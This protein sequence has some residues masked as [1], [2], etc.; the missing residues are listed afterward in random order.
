[1]KTLKI[2]A[3]LLFAV[4][5]FIGAAACAQNTPVQTSTTASVT[6]SEVS[7]IVSDESVEEESKSPVPEQWQDNGIF[8]NYYE[9]A[10]LMMSEL[11]LEEKIGQML[12]TR[13]PDTDAAATA[14]KYNIGGYVLFGR[15]FENKTKDDVIRTIRSYQESSKIPMA[16]ASDEEGGTVT[17]VSW[18][19]NLTEHFFQSPRDIYESGGMDT[20]RSD[21]LEKSQLLHEL[22]INVNLAPV[23]DICTDPDDFMYDRS[24]G[25]SPEV[26]ATFVK[27]FVDESQKNMVSA[28]L[29]HFPGYGGNDDTHFGIAIDK[30][31][32]ENFTENDFVPFAAGIEAGAH[33]VLVNHNIVKCIDESNPSSLSAAVHKKLREELKFTGIIVTDDMDMEGVNAYLEDEYSACV[34]AVLAG[35]DMVMISDPGKAVDDIKKAVDDGKIDEEIINHSVMRIL[36]WKYAKG[37]IK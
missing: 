14:K 15:D 9:K 21:T 19:D 35:N 32:Y 24:L 13:C 26:T 5:V 22:G 18:N 33:F 3:C 29:K 37:M 10:Y 20:I 11:S 25:Q 31:T 8:S 17:R 23:C 34:A 2:T 7:D 4:S 28:T 30:R 27:T 36:A 16:I 1:M 12:F 6:S